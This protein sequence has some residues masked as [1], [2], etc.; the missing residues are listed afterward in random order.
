MPEFDPINSLLVEIRQEQIA[1]LKSLQQYRSENTP[2]APAREFTTLNLPL[3]INP[4]PGA[5]P[6]ATDLSSCA[7]DNYELPKTFQRLAILLKS[8]DVMVIRSGHSC[9]YS[10]CE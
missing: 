5:A 9:F 8:Y 2:L 3:D 6:P 1:C 10:R 7:K 4:L